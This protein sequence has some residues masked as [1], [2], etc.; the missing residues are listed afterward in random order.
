MHRTKLQSHRVPNP[1][2]QHLFSLLVFQSPVKQ[3]IGKVAVP[4]R[5]VCRE[6]S[7]HSQRPLYN[8]HC[9]QCAVLDSPWG[10]GPVSLEERLG[11]R[12]SDTEPGQGI[13][14]TWTELLY[15]GACSVA[16]V[17]GLRLVLLQDDNRK[18]N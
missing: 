11:L 10:T 18:K 13:P 16:Q 8:L 1:S 7:S 14:G 17:A 4:G 6:H 2:R 12:D 9:Q 5:W 3:S 15:T